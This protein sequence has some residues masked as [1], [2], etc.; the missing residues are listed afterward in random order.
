MKY[1]IIPLLLIFTA[2]KKEGYERVATYKGDYD[3]AYIHVSDL[4][5]MTPDEVNQKVGVRVRENGNIETFINGSLHRK[6]KFEK[7]SAGGNDTISCVCKW[8]NNSPIKVKLFEGDK[9]MFPVFPYKE[10][11]NFF[12]KK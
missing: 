5:F 3:L 9:L 8:E 12:Y 6:Y 4:E 2:C 11:Q 10:E 1:L 7:V